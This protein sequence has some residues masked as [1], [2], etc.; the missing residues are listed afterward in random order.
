MKK[1]TQFAMVFAV[2]FVTSASFAQPKCNH[3]LASAENDLL[4]NTNPVKVRMAKADAPTKG[5]ESTRAGTR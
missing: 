2:I 5:K 1:V 3:R 4:K